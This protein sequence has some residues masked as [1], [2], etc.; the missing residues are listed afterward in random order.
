MHWSYLGVTGNS[1]AW[2]VRFTNISAS[3]FTDIYTIF[4]EYNLETIGA[5]IPPKVRT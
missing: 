5:K 4:Y 2:N 3:T 1:S